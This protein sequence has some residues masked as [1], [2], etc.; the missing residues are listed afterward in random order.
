MTE[1]SEYIIS[2]DAKSIASKQKHKCLELSYRKQQNRNIN[3]CFN[4]SFS[5]EYLDDRVKD[6]VEIAAY[7]FSAEIKYASSELDSNEDT[8]RLFDVYIEVRDY[9]FWKQTEIN[10]ILARLLK[11]LTGNEY[12][13]NFSKLAV[14][15]KSPPKRKNYPKEKILIT[16][17]S[18]GIDSAAGAID[19]LERNP[20]CKVYM[21]SHQ[22][23]LPGTSSTQNNLFG[24]ISELYPG[25]CTHIKFRCGLLNDHSFDKNYATRAL[26]Y[27]AVSFAVSQLYSTDKYYVYENGISAINFRGINSIDNSTGYTVHPKAMHLLE[28]LYM[29]ISGKQFTI[30]MPFLFKT[31]AE[32]I[33]VLR[34]WDRISLLKHTVSCDRRL[35]IPLGFSHCGTCPSCITRRIALFASDLRQ[36]HKDSFYYDFL[37]ESNL[38]AQ[39]EQ[40]METMLREMIY[41]INQ[42]SDAFCGLWEDDI[43]II[44]ENLPYANSYPSVVEKIY[45]LCNR[46]FHDMKK[47]INLM[48]DWYDSPWSIYNGGAFFSLLNESR[49]YMLELQARE[50]G[51]TEVD[52]SNVNVSLEN[53]S[54]KSYTTEG[55]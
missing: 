2:C 36:E 6:L 5:F 19:S 35:S 18:G 28:M 53:R 22:S 20:E 32:V 29:H 12:K 45:D 10:T 7:L 50:I 40:M 21:V 24:K 15:E 25:R 55:Y 4:D 38:T 3:L 33:S 49:G 39:Q 43:T 26:L 17:L 8:P 34:S 31:K 9:N 44:E 27:N 14:K 42:R 11:F 1:V 48:R 47:A 52:Y 37:A 13:F 41:F 46:H 54:A 30:Q 23:G 51:E 16:F